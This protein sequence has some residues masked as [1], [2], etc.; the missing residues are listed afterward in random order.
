MEISSRFDKLQ[1]LIIGRD[2][3]NDYKAIDRCTKRIKKPTAMI[4]VNEF[5]TDHKVIFMTEAVVK[6]E[7]IVM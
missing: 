2:N 3:D 4:T 5:H 6:T 7:W 1:L